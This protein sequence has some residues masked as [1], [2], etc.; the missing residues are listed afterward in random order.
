MYYFKEIGII[1]PCTKSGRR[2][3]MVRKMWI[4]WRWNSVQ[5]WRVFDLWCSLHKNIRNALVCEAHVDD[6][7]CLYPCRCQKETS[8]LTGKGYAQTFFQKRSYLVDEWRVLCAEPFFQKWS[9]AH[10]YQNK[11]SNTLQFGW[12]FKNGDPWKL[13]FGAELATG[14]KNFV[15]FPKLSAEDTNNRMPEAGELRLSSLANRCLWL[16]RE[17]FLHQSWESGSPLLLLIIYMEVTA[18]S[19]QGP[20]DLSIC[21]VGNL[22]VLI[23]AIKQSTNR[24]RPTSGMMRSKAITNEAF[25]MEHMG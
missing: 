2:I 22:E 18:L 25:T 6:A 23:F 4:L 9:S 15:C 10:A 12:H 7:V 1:L 14:N 13:C 24:N 21:Q 17:S 3:W 5:C 20:E 8:I 19:H 16:V 11:W